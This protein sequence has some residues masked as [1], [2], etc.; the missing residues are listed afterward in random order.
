[1]KTRVPRASA[2]SECDERPICTIKNTAR[3]AEYCQL[4]ANAV[5]AALSVLFRAGRR[6]VHR[7][8]GGRAQGGQ[9]SELSQKGDLRGD[10]PHGTRSCITWYMHMYQQVD[11]DRMK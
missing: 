2:A 4:T 9:V 1:M 6:G 8:R 10:V 7:K 3:Y 5:A 11:V